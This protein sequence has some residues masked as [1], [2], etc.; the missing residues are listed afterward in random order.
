MIITST[1]A[2]LSSEPPSARERRR[3]CGTC[4]AH[5]PKPPATVPGPVIRPKPVRRGRRPKGPVAGVSH[6]TRA[7]ISAQEAAHVTVKLK[8]FLPVLRHCREYWVLRRAFARGCARFGFRLVH[9]AV[10]NDHMHFV[11]EA[12]DR[13]ALT[14]G[15]QGLLVRI[16]KALN[17]LWDRR[18]KVFP[19]R[20]HAR[21]LRT[22]R[23]VRTVLRYV[24]HNGRKH[25]AQGRRVRVRGRIDLFTS[26][27]WFDGFSVKV[28]VEGLERVIRPVALACSW[29]L[30]EG[31]KRHGL[32]GL[33]ELP[34]GIGAAS[35]QRPMP[36]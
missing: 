27:P 12:R 30:R 8:R 24:M 6:K 28:I 18:G 26:A 3:G 25:A 15:M 7:K 34:R 5:I 21:I 16:A 35:A 17:K 22:A 36:S 1:S 13:R 9:Y 29:M 31:W 33:D 23:D 2:V 14:R 11:A 32:I 4:S 20:Y 19:D 10:L